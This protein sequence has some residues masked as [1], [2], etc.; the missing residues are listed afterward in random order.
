MSNI[1]DVTDAD[2][3]QEVI[4]ASKQ[5]PVLV[6]FWAPW[7]SPCRMIVPVL[8][9]LAVELVGKVKIVK[10]NVEEYK[11]TISTFGVRG[12]PT[13][14]VFSKGELSNVHVGTASVKDIKRLFNL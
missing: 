11:E 9:Q 1:Q 3:T 14:M 12:V 4:E 7:C 5:I 13:L 2:F 8:Q 10:L 6:D